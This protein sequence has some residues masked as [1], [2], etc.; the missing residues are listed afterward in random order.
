[1]SEEGSPGPPRS[2]AWHLAQEERRVQAGGAVSKRKQRKN[3]LVASEALEDSPAPVPP[4]DVV[5]F[6]LIEEDDVGQAYQT[7]TQPRRREQH[8]RDKDATPRPSVDT[9]VL[10]VHKQGVELPA[11]NG[12]IKINLAKFILCRVTEEK[13]AELKEAE[14]QSVTTDHWECLLHSNTSGRSHPRFVK[15]GGHC[16]SHAPL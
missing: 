5:L 16:Q 1:M 2:R 3:L 9:S 8:A 13:L 15:V 7:P 11:S 14:S 12:T 6:E 10:K 4:D